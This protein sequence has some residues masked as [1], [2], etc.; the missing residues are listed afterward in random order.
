METSRSD[1]PFAPKGK[2]SPARAALSRLGANGACDQHLADDLLK[3]LAIN[4][5]Q[6]CTKSLHNAR[7]KAL[8]DVVQAARSYERALRKL[9]E[10]APGFLSLELQ[11]RGA[12]GQRHLVE[13]MGIP[14][15][16]PG[17][18]EPDDIDVAFEPELGL[19][20]DHRPV[21][22][23]KATMQ[24]ATAMSRIAAKYAGL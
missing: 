4:Y 22:I 5:N 13:L 15:Q 8:D 10:V 23:F 19:A 12:N 17:F 21:P 24:R 7:I 11:G 1:S 18:V 14:V 3:K 16:A 20:H 2:I 9:A 6:T